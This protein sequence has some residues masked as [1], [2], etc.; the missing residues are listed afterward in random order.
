M[1]AVS[2]LALLLILR[3]TEG[4]RERYISQVLRLNG[5]GGLLVLLP[6]CYFYRKDR[7]ARVVCHVVEQ[8][9]Q[10]LFFGEIILLILLGGALS[11]YGNLLMRAL[12]PVLDATE[13]Y[14]KISLLEQGY[15]IPELFF[16][17]AVVAPLAE[18]GV[19]RWLVYL[20]LRD[21]LP[22]R[23][24]TA[25]DKSGENQDRNKSIWVAAL[26]SAL[27][28]GGYHGNL[29]QAVYAALL[30]F[31]FA[32]I[33]EWTGNIFSSFLLHFGANAS[34]IFLSE[35]LVQF[36][37]QKQLM[38]MGY[39]MLADLAVLFYGIWYFYRVGRTHTGRLE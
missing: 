11:L 31:F 22:V 33:L 19:F 16:W 15:R 25:G 32:L 24:G 3:F 1:Q 6:V 10:A 17:A 23:D 30:G 18:E 27:I 20:R 29:V 2:Y 9:E 34:S 26:I 37:G 5:I 8:Q 39:L 36:T 13:Y 7:S 28:F 14:Q 12:T 4:G 38:I 35:I 21:Y